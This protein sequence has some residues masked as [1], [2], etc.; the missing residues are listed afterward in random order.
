MTWSLRKGGQDHE[1]WWDKIYS[2]NNLLY[3]SCYGPFV[4]AL[5]TFSKVNKFRRWEVYPVNVYAEKTW[6]EDEEMAGQ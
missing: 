1:I 5:K 2:G 3:L 6:G 4:G